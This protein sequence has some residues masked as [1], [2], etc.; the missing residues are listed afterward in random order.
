MDAVTLAD[1]PRF[2]ILRRLKHVPLEIRALV[3]WGGY[4]IPG[5]RFDQVPYG[6]CFDAFGSPAHIRLTERVIP[7]H[8]S[9]RYQD[10]MREW[11]WQMSV[12]EPVHWMKV[13]KEETNPLKLRIQARRSR[14]TG[15]LIRVARKRVA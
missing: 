11:Y 2:T 4:Y 8:T 12:M 7:M 10:R 9:T 13:A 6:I 3:F 15:G 1:A 14:A 5:G